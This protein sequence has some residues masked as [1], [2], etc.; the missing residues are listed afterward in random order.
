MRGLVNRWRLIRELLTTNGAKQRFGAAI[1]NGP[2]P[3][4][5][6]LNADFYYLGLSRENAKFARGTAD[7]LRH[8]L[9]VRLFGKHNSLDWNFEFVG[10]FGSFGDDGILAWTAASDTGWTFAGRSKEHHCP[11]LELVDHRTRRYEQHS[12]SDLSGA[13]R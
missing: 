7:E 9:G 11:E 5:P 6:G 2:L 12:S 8:S 10:Q 3:L 13:P 1:S 4:I